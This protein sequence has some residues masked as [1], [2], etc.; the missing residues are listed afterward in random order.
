[1]H[2]RD[3]VRRYGY[4]SVLA[5]LVL[6]LLPGARAQEQTP[7]GRVT[8]APQVSAPVTPYLF[9]GDVRDLPAPITWRPGDP[10]KEIPRR[11]YPPPG[12]EDQYVGR[13]EPFVDLLHEWQLAAPDNT[14][15]AFVTPTRNFLGQGFSGVNPPDTA[16]DVGPNHYIQ[17]INSSGGT[18]VRIYDKAEP[19][20]AV[21]ANF[22]L[23]SLGSGNCASGF[24]D[25][26]A[27]YDR[28]ADRWLLSEFSGSGNRLC[29]YISQTADPLSGGWLNYD[30]QAPSFP[31]YPKYGVWPTDANSGLGSYVV[32]SND[33][34]PGIY[35][36]DRGAM[37]SGSPGTYQRMTIPDLPGF[38]FE[39]PAPA[40]LDGPNSPPAGA[41]AIIMRHRDTENHSGPAA[42]GDL[43]EMWAFDVDWTTPANTTLTTLPSIDVDEFDSDLCG[44]TSFFCFTQPNSGTTLDPLREVIMNRLQYMNHG[45]FET[46]VGNLVTDVDGSDHGGV[47]W[48]ELRRQ[49][50]GWSLYQEGTYSIDADH[51]W[52]AAGAMDQSQ[53]IALA[54]NISSNTTF[55][56]LRYTGRLAGDPLDVMTQ[57]EA[58]IAAGNSP[59]SSNRYGDYAAMNLDPADDCTFWFTGEFNPSGSWGTQIA[60]FAFDACGCE[61]EPAPL[62]VTAEANGDNRIDVSFDDADLPTVVE[63]RVRRS[64]TPGGPYET[65]ATVADTSPGVAS[66]PGY[67]YE[68]IGVSGGTTYYY[69]VV[70]SDGVACTSSASN[71]SS[72]TATGPCTLAPSFAGVQSVG[73]TYASTCTIDLSWNAATANCSGPIVYNIYRSTVPG[74][75]PSALTLLVEDVPATSYSDLDALLGDTQYYYVVR[76]V[77]QANGVEEANT[78]EGVGFPQGP[79]T[80]GT[81]L[82]D[83]GD[84]G[85]AKL[86]PESP[87]SVD[88]D[89]GTAGSAVY[90]TG[91]YG[92][93]TCAG[94][95]SDPLLLGAGSMLEFQSHYDIEPSW[96]KGEVQVSTDGGAN[97]QRVAVNYP[98]NST[99]TSDGCGLPTGTYFTGTN[100]SY[101]LYGADLSAWEGS[102]VLLRFAMSS[103][104]SVIETGWWVD[105]LSITNVDVPGVCTTGSLCA[106]NPLVN[107]LPDGP[108]VACLGDAQQ[109]T[110]NLTGGSG[111]FVFQWTRD[112]VD[113]PGETT[114]TLDVDDA[115]S[116]VY[117]VDVRATSC[118]DDARDGVPTSIA[119]HDRPTFDG[120]ESAT[121]TQGATCTIDL[122][123]GVADSVCPG[124]VTYS[125]YR[126]TASPVAIVAGNRI[127][128]GLGSQSYRDDE[129]LASGVTYH[130]VVRAVEGST[131][132][133]D[134][135]LVEA[136][137]TP[138]G[139]SGDCVTGG[140][141]G[142]VTAPDGSATTDPLRAARLTPSGDTLEITW[143]AISCP[144][145]NYNLLY[146]DL[147]G[148]KTYALGGAECAIGTAGTHNW[149]AVPS[150]DLFFLIVGSNGANVESSW[151]TRSSGAQ[152]KGPISSNRCGA[153]MKDI[154]ATCP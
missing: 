65:I 29:V 69:I 124:P 79:L 149:N 22:M 152:R 44:L 23:D 132:Q 20:P 116:H 105:D 74:S 13:S 88:P 38:G 107:V 137:A 146:G 84:S 51:R 91:A 120:I 92:N 100:G 14:S 138:T 76:A 61:L 130:Y 134:G 54:Y 125:V 93:N 52:M 95:V 121:N 119:W 11:F 112:G 106:E 68:D 41:R 145:V 15:G 10:I 56:G 114:A 26:I 63:Y 148:V 46:L 142:A 12:T 113:I 80:Q 64:T 90:K 89:E 143:D 25:P 28:Q 118:D 110:A 48:F 19:Q 36:L 86:T 136:S 60:S 39:A 108:I 16:G 122:A 31:D 3:S 27:L 18:A 59:N 77:D 33:G 43:L 57:A 97:W 78:V 129:G 67:I 21:L 115:D 83:A 34:G 24:G 45:D 139:S 47:R 7:A 85:V 37:L 154:T 49:G 30:F 117:N 4:T 104:T 17:L 42:P 40:D 66:G 75:V 123:W 82:D 96:D 131:G 62:A 5:L 94:I 144:S 35:A 127:A 153:Q 135:N 151:G 9:D 141:T 133:D 99:N 128:E 55:P 147:A 53:N 98:G 50:G 6:C 32:T 1:M 81:W 109:L 126:S 140:P 101:A 2:P 71:E 111:P 70:G 73:T 58:V 8:H 87:W 72:A 102:E 150:A 103:D